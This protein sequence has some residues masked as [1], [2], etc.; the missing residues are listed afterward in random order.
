MGD[1]HG[2]NSR[3]EPEGEHRIL[4]LSSTMT[5]HWLLPVKRCDGQTR[6]VSGVLHS[7]QHDQGT[8]PVSCRQGSD[9]HSQPCFTH[10]DF[11][12]FQH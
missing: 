1:P 11:P 10:R 2:T 9:T 5:S 7:S 8:L 4:I 12:T 6:A 3:C